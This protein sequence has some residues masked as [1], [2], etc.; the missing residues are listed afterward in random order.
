VLLRERYRCQVVGHSAEGSQPWFNWMLRHRETGLAVG[1]LQATV[2][3]QNGESVAEIAWVVASAHQGRGY[4]RQAA[5]V[6]VR[7][8]W[9]QGF[10]G[11]QQDGR[12]RRGALGRLNSSRHRRCSSRSRIGQGRRSRWDAGPDKVEHPGA[13][14]PGHWTPGW[15]LREAE[16]RHRKGRGSVARSAPTS[17]LRGPGPGCGAELG[18][19]RSQLN[20]RRAVPVVSGDFLWCSSW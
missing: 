7:W 19:G 15:S 20:C 14:I 8:P 17:W 11:S 1:F 13:G 18:S 9:L 16:N 2:S 6:L 3:T 10:D 5:E 12:R 4:A